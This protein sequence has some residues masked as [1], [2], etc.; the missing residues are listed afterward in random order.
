MPSRNYIALE[1]YKP[2][3]YL[4]P[5]VELDIALDRE[6]W[7][8]HSRLWFERESADAKEFTLDGVN[9]SLQEIAIDQRELAAEEYTI[10]GEELKILNPPEKGILEIRVKINPSENLSGLG[11][12]ESA[13]LLITQMEADGF[14]RLSYF[15]DRPDVLSTYRVCYTW[16]PYIV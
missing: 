9:L 2:P 10:E 5:K 8:V 6:D 16:S 4:I 1:D 13:N 15:P 11:L 7:S 3:A 12:Y 14:R